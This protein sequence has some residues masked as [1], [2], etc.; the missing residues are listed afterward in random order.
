MSTA[1]TTRVEPALEAIGLKKTFTQRGGLPGSPVRKVHAVSDVSFRL[2]QGTTLGIVG[3]SGCGKSTLARLLLQLIAP[4]AGDVLLDGSQILQTRTGLKAYRS[5]V[6]M[7][8]QDSSASLNPRLTIEQSITFGPMV[9]GISREI[10]RQ[11]AHQLLAQVGLE[12]ALYAGRYPHELSGGQRQRVN[13]ARALALKP[14]IV[15]FDEAVSALDKSVEAQVLNL[16]NELKAKLD[17]SFIFISHDLNVVRYIADTLIVMYLGEVVEAGP[18]D[19]IY[20]QPH[21]PYTRA[22]LASMPSIDPENRTHVAP[23]VGDPPSPID[24]PPGCRF[25][26]RCPFAEPVCTTQQPTEN[27]V[28]MTM[29]RCHIADPA[30]AHTKAGQAHE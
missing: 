18:V 21:H 28:G 4:D 17:L 27:P 2:K 20:E 15:I 25:A 6:Q 30:S 13:I 7:V 3:E 9:H 1:T 16:L 12:P 5:Q 29:V 10:A 11:D 24:L 22:L 26:P 8:F 14:K 23:I 19:R